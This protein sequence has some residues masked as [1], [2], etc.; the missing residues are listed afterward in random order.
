[1][2]AA[3]EKA[4]AE[5]A[6]RSAS[7]PAIS[8]LHNVR[9]PSLAFGSEARA[10]AARAVSCCAWLLRLGHHGKMGF[11]VRALMSCHVCYINIG[12]ITGVLAGCV[13]ACLY[14]KFSLSWSVMDGA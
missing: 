3:A 9:A 14:P 6:G 13:S 12:T 10:C 2:I 4:A 8:V 11:H 1:M 7:E 5:K